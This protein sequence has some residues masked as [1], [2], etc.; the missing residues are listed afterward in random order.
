MEQE[1]ER[2]RNVKVILMQDGGLVE[3]CVLRP[4][5]RPHDLTPAGRPL[6]QGGVASMLMMSHIRHHFACC[7]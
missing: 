7:C 1:T 5:L 2:D 4:W 3:G 6:M